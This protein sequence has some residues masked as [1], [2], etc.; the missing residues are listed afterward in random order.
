MPNWEVTVFKILYKYFLS[1]STSATELAK[2]F[3]CIVYIPLVTNDLPGS[4]SIDPI[5][6]RNKTHQYWLLVFTKWCKLDSSCSARLPQHLFLARSHLLNGNPCSFESIS[7]VRIR[8]Y[9]YQYQ[10]D[11]SGVLPSS[12][13]LSWR[14]SSFCC[15]SLRCLFITGKRLVTVTIVK[16]STYPT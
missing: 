3:S 8:Y 16:G 15:T 2:R 4:T 13:A 7:S 5:S 11:I 10:K 9:K 14:E 6:H 12:N 1:N